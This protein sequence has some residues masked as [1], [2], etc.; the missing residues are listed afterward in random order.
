MPLDTTVPVLEVLGKSVSET[1]V[2][3]L[4]PVLQTWPV[5]AT[6]TCADAFRLV[7]HDFVTV[8]EVLTG[9]MH[10]CDAG[11]FAVTSRVAPLGSVDPLAMATSGWLSDELVELSLHVPVSPA[12]KVL[13]PKLGEFGVL[14][15]TEMV[16]QPGLV[17]V[18]AGVKLPIVSKTVTLYRVPTPVFVTTPLTG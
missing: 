13:C 2:T 14:F 12:P 5:N 16:S 18:A 6:W 4:G 3:W 1:P 15:T 17:Q 10:V 7:V 11:S 9:F 8:N